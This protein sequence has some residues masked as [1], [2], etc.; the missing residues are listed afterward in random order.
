MFYWIQAKFKIKITM[1][2]DVRYY[3]GSVSYSC[4]NNA[5]IGAVL[6][7]ITG[8]PTPSFLTKINSF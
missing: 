7:P 8:S 5:L 3:V 6:K 2:R 1:Y 4:V